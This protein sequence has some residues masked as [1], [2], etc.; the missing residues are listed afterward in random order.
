MIVTVVA[1][2]LLALE[3][4]ATGDD[5]AIPIGRV[6]TEEDCARVV[7]FLVTDLSDYIVGQTIKI[8]GGVLLF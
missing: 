4:I 5:Q 7:E 8:C 3:E 6:G 1:E 2:H